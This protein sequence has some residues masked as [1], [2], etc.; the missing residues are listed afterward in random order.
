MDT[1]GG[2]VHEIK[3]PAKFDEMQAHKNRVRWKHQ[4]KKSYD[5]SFRDI[6]RNYEEVQ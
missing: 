1:T 4:I 5:Q 2:I 3:L 6:A